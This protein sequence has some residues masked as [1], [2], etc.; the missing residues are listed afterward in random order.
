MR[1]SWTRSG[2]LVRTTDLPPEKALL[3]DSWLVDDGQVRGLE[4]HAGRFGSSCAKLFPD[5]TQ[6]EVDGFLTAVFTVLPPAGRW[7]PRIEAHP[8]PRLALWIR[9]APPPRLVARLWVGEDRDV[10]T[11][12]GHKGPDVARLAG[13]RNQAV[14]AGADDALLLSGDGH[15]LETAHA[16]L[17]WWR[18]DTLCLPDARLPILRSVTRRLVERL[19]SSVEVRQESSALEGLSGCEVWTMNALHGISPVVGWVGDGVPRTAVPE[20]GRL[21]TWRAALG[22]TARERSA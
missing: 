17:L 13:L 20:S 9:P 5:L 10:L 11:T 22:A 3:V 15:V 6:S 1:W 2:E 7:F 12:P 16:A 19:A 4:L 18:G 8:G 21:A 14:A